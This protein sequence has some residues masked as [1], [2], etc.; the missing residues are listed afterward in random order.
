VNEFAMPENPLDYS[1]V[2]PAVIIFVDAARVAVLP[3]VA[4]VLPHGIQRLV[5]FIRVSHELTFDAAFREELREA[6]TER[7]RGFKGDLTPR[8]P[9][10]IISYHGAELLPPLLSNVRSAVEGFHTQIEVV[11]ISDQFSD[12]AAYR[13]CESLQRSL[14]EVIACAANIYIF[15]PGRRGKVFQPPDA[16]DAFVQ[17]V[18]AWIATEASRFQPHECLTTLRF[19]KAGRICLAAFD[20]EELPDIRTSAVQDIERQIAAAFYPSF[21]RDVMQRLNDAKYVDLTPI[22]RATERRIDVSNHHAAEILRV[23]ASQ[24]ETL[25]ELGQRLTGLRSEAS[26]VVAE[27]LTEC[28]IQ[29]ERIETR[30]SR[31][32]AAAPN[33]PLLERIFNEYSF[34]AIYWFEHGLGRPDGLA[35]RLSAHFERAAEMHRENGARALRTAIERDHYSWSSPQLSNS[36]RLALLAKSMGVETRCIDSAWPTLFQVPPSFSPLTRDEVCHLPRRAGFLD[37]LELKCN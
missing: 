16:L 20:G 2:P 15:S 4:R 3:A 24:S 13:P 6:A 33:W 18:A 27:L 5:S 22:L 14:G 30:W 37:V 29:V 11:V 28:A 32:T 8:L 17:F 34:P 36:R 21:S 31:L 9:I 23:V 7:S 35:R 1:R 25:H 10:I 12:T 26:P 19:R